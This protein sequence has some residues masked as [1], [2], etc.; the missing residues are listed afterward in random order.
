MVLHE[1]RER[2]RE[3]IG[4][5]NGGAACVGVWGTAVETVSGN[6]FG[7]VMGAACVARVKR[8]RMVLKLVRQNGPGLSEGTW[9]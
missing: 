2:N 5:R 9:S 4:E 3:Y 8:G 6:V 7:N 1:A